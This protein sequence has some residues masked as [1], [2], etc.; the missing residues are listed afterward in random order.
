MSS[1]RKPTIP[2]SPPASSTTGRY[3]TPSGIVWLRTRS[4][5][6]AIVASRPSVM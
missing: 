3:C 1:V 5:A 6:S 4:V 2:T